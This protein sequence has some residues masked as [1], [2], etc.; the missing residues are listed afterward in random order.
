MQ[1]LSFSS[2]TTVTTMERQI[3]SGVL[4]SRTALFEGC[5]PARPD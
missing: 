4:D 5:D 1:A 3:F 2:S